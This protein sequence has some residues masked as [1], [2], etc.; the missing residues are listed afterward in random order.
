MKNYI[1]TTLLILSGLL[2]SHLSFSQEVHTEIDQRIIDMYGAA[3]CQQ[4]VGEQPEFIRYMNFYVQ[5]AYQIMEGVPARKLPYFDDISSITNTRT[6]KNLTVD[7]LRNLNILL[8]DIE[9]K[10][11]QYLTYKV[12]ETGT[13][14]IFIAPKNLLEQ[15]NDLKKRGGVQ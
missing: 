4:M 13:V 12:G 3:R 7:D 11:D 9:R 6:G 1:L 14:V 5:N 15:Y 10:N 8:L 2:G